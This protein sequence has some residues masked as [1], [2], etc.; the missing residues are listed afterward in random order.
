[1]SSAPPG[2]N[3]ARAAFT[4][5]ELLA[6]IAIIGVLAGIV[7]GV[8]RRATEAGKMARAK[9]ELATLSAAL[10]TYKRTYGDYPQVDDEAKLL[11]ALIGRRGP[12]SDTVINGRAL[13]ETSRFVVA[14]P[15]TPTV[16]A[17]PF[18]DAS[19]ALFDP[20]GQPYVY[21]YKTTAPW[22]NSSYLLYSIGPDGVDSAALLAGGFPDIA[23]AVNADNIH[24]NR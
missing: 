17:D 8:G 14:R 20:W 11:Q 3:S 5:L 1:M 19:A 12:T 2:A 23:P 18:T 21:A 7:I 15:A 10:E 16:P 22:N 24:A 13:V 6:V 9:A 4:L